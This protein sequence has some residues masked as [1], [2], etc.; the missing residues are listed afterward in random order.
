M[1]AGQHYTLSSKHIF[2]LKFL[3]TF[4]LNVKHNISFFVDCFLNWIPLTITAITILTK[5]SKS[6]NW[7]FDI[8]SVSGLSRRNCKPV[9]T[10]RDAFICRTGLTINRFF[11]PFGSQPG[12]SRAHSAS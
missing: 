9:T 10:Q 12:V 11:S 4:R 2:Y 1:T 5:R 6:G 7:R 3:L 8:L